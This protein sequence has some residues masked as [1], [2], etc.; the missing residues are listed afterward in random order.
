MANARQIA[1]AIGVIIE[2]SKPLEKVWSIGITS[3]PEKRREE[4]NS[5]ALWNHWPANSLDEAKI[6]FEYY[7]R[8][9]MLQPDTG[10]EYS[11]GEKSYIY[12]Y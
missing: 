6:V 10:A 4:L 7:T 11:R 5:P 9:M 8:D 1:R 2:S 12:I 3:D